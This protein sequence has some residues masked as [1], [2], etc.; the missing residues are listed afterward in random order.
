MVFKLK[1]HTIVLI[2]VVCHTFCQFGKSALMDAGQ[3]FVGGTK[4]PG[5]HF[6]SDESLLQCIGSFVEV[7]YA[8]GSVRENDHIN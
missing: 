7:N 5:Q 3:K 4:C 8:D 1:C 2:Y 6:C